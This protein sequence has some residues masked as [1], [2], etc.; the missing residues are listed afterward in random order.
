MSFHYGCASVRRGHSLICNAL[1]IC[2]LAAGIAAKPSIRSFR[3]KGLAAGLANR[4]P[5]LFQT[6]LLQFLLIAPIAAQIII[7]ILL[8]GDLRVELSAAAFTDDFSDRKVGT[9]AGYFLLVPAFQK[10]L[11]FILPITVPCSV[12]HHTHYLLLC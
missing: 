1:P 6:P 8:C 4:I 7:A 11:V 3:G 10:L 5:A 12:W 2:F 9:F